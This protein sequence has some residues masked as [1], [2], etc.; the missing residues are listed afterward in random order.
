MSLC[1]YIL[2][3]PACSLSTSTNEVQTKRNNI[4]RA[5]LKYI[6][7]QHARDLKHLNTQL[8]TPRMKTRIN[9]THIQ[10]GPYKLN[11]KEAHKFTSAKALKSGNKDGKIQRNTRVQKH[12]RI[13]IHENTKTKYIFKKNLKTLKNTL[14]K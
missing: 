12:I 9:K 10:N 13:A 3:N 11:L 7:H 14:K 1:L 6:K 5:I 4:D 8:S 2:F